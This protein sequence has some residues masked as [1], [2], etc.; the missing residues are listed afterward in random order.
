MEYRLLGNTGLIVSEIGFGSWAIGGDEWG[1]VK[2]NESLDAIEKAI[3][4]GVNFIDTADV[5]GLGHSETL[6]AKAINN[7]R[8]DIILST[9]GGLIGHHY[10]P[11]Q[12]AVYGDP[13]KIIDAFE[14]SLLRL[15]TDYIDVYFC[16]IWWDKHEETE[17][18]LQAFQTLKK[19]GKV[20]AV[21]VSTNDLDYIKHFNQDN[22]LD[23]VQFDY[24]ILNKEPEK[25][26]LPYIEKH[27]LGAVIRGP[28]KMGILTGKFNHETQFPDDDLRKDW[29]K[30]KWFKDSL[31]KVEKLRSLVRSNRSLAQVALRY[32]LSHPAV[33]VAIPGA[34]NS[35]QVEENSSHLTRPLLLDN[36]IEFIKQL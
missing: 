31:N 4:L 21:G 11:N 26:I 23:V 7:R 33:S 25:D 15:K 32:V 19:S 5:Y 27:N 20:R 8:Q 34:K 30:E 2:D 24:S 3:D 28:L 16:H 35:T 12:P 9:K 14:A 6:V 29:P 1:A 10:D 36:E 18:F 17:A 13:Q 22:D